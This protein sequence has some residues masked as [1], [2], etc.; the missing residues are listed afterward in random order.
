MRIHSAW[1]N[2]SRVRSLS[3]GQCVMQNI[4]A[5]ITLAIWMPFLQLV[6]TN[7]CIL[8]QAE[9]AVITNNE[10]KCTGERNEWCSF[11]CKNQSYNW[12]N[13]RGA[14]LTQRVETVICINNKWR[15]SNSTNMEPVCFGKHFKSIL[16]S[17][18]YFSG[19]EGS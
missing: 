17:M 1:Q 13:P 10:Q 8:P 14:T 7:S 4:L 9:K 19:L 18:N 5:E 11:Q 6:R 16:A 2:L 15:N 3:T 12:P